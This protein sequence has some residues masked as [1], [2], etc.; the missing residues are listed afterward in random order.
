[1]VAILT[2]LSECYDHDDAVVST[3][4]PKPGSQ[5]L[6]LPRMSSSPRQVQS[7]SFG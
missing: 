3:Q 6:A 5:P 7:R 1:M 2:H 4:T